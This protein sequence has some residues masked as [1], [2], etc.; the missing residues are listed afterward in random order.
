MDA[1]NPPKIFLTTRGAR[2]ASNWG[3]LGASFLKICI[4]GIFGD[5]PSNLSWDRANKPILTKNILFLTPQWL[6]EGR[7]QG[8]LFRGLKGGFGPSL[9]SLKFFSVFF[10]KFVLRGVKTNFIFHGLLFIFLGGQ[11]WGAKGLGVNKEGQLE[12]FSFKLELIQT[13]LD[14]FYYQ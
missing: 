8:G 9:E 4:L 1:R 2:G 6:G 10:T 5:I 11:G 12:S 3:Q 14:D 13:Y 7:D